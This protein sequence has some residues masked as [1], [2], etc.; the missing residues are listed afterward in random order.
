VS[1]DETFLERIGAA[2]AAATSFGAG[3]SRWQRVLM[4][5]L[6]VVIVGFLAAAVVSQW[7]KLPDIEWRFAPGWLALSFLG[8]VLFQFIHATLWVAILEALGTPIHAMRG[9]AVWSLTLLA[10][11]VP[12][13]VAL[14]VSRMAL[15]EREGVPKR[16]TGA[17]I[18]YELGFT[19]AG[20]AALGAYFVVTLPSLDDEPLRWLALAAPVLSLVALDPA[21]FHRLADAALRRLGRA[22]LPL[23]LSRLQVLG[24]FAAFAASFLVAGFSVYAF[25]EGIHGVASE[26]IPTVVGAYSVGFAASVVAFMLPGGLGAREGAMAAA[27]SPAMPLAVALAVAVGIR[28]AQMA[29]EVLYA[30]VTPMLAR[31]SGK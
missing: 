31:R 24:F 8:L 21:V 1:R 10:R 14:A 30:A 20:A 19:F 25:A 11:Y 22:T 3:Q 6:A 7:S 17:S 28:L 13:N 9:R 27:L 4:V 18:V 15:A 5:A 29:V 2:G 16:I 23:S 12:T 26:D